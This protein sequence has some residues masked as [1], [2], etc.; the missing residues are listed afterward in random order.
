M[1]NIEYYNNIILKIYHDSDSNKLALL[2]S[3][4]DRSLYIAIIDLNNDSTIHFDIKDAFID[5]LGD[6]FN[7]PYDLTNKNL[8]AQ[9]TAHNAAYSTFRNLS[10]TYDCDF[11]VAHSVHAFEVDFS[12]GRILLETKHTEYK[13]SGVERIASKADFYYLI[14]NFDGKI[15]FRENIITSRHGGHHDDRDYLRFLDPETIIYWGGFSE[16]DQA[17]PLKLWK[18]AD[19]KYAEIDNGAFLDDDEPCYDSA[20]SCALHKEAKLIA[21]AFGSHEI[22]QYSIK[23]L[24]LG[25]ENDFKIIFN[26]IYEDESLAYI[27]FSPSGD[28]F[29]TLEYTNSEEHTAPNINIR[30]YSFDE[31]HVPKNIVRTK[32]NSHSDYIKEIIYSSSEIIC[33]ITWDKIFLYNIVN[34]DEIRILNRDRE[35]PFYISADKLFYLANKKLTIFTVE[36]GESPQYTGN[37]EN[38]RFNY[39]DKQ[40]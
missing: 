2:K 14:L 19:G 39:E 23:I 26:Y 9:I 10:Y 12:N 3:K 38:Q 35:S 33:L 1:I 4:L 7:F 15:L 34:G 30:I 40:Y 22:P 21:L 17:N 37:E 20:H 31:S 36:E 8:A 27:A 16:Y 32:I 24:K 25:S 13:I 5:L 11:I 18:F 28:E 6:H 29:S